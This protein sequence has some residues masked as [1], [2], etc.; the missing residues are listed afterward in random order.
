MPGNTQFKIQVATDPLFADLIYEN[1]VAEAICPSLDCGNGVVDTGEQCDDGNKLG[2]DC[3]SEF[4]TTEPYCQ[5]NDPANCAPICGDGQVKHTEECDDGD[6]IT[7]NCAYGL[8]SCTVCRA[9]CTN[10]PGNP[11]VCGDGTL[12]SG[13]EACDDGNT[14][15]GDGCRSNCTLEV[16]GDGILDSNE[17]CDD[18][19]TTANDGCSATCAIENGWSC[20]TGL[21]CNA[22]CGDVLL[23]GAEQ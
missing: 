17:D 15:D 6:T 22:V 23:K 9:D 13:N 18:G 20:P 5:C 2:G 8:T 3:C 19:N 21:V 14:V 1:N 4:C 16:C 7:N 11:I 10:G 12:Q